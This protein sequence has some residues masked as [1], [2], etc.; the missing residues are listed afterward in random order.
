MTKNPSIGIDLLRKLGILNFYLP[1]LLYCYGV[2]QNI[3]HEYTVYE[4]LLN[5]C[6]ACETSDPILKLSALFH[7]IGKPRT[8]GTRPDGSGYSFHQ[9]EYMG[10]GIAEVIMN[11]L[12]F[13]NKEIDRVSLLVSSHMFMMV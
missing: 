8:I 7:D 6:D 13:S 9:H 2:E 3:Y 4:H 11:R 1:E 5:A 10:A 12:S